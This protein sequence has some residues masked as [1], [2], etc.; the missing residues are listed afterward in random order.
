MQGSLR[1]VVAS[2]SDVQAERDLVQ[3]VADEVNYGAAGERN[4]VLQ[5]SRW[6]KDAFPSSTQAAHRVSSTPF[7]ILPSATYSSAFSGN[8]CGTPVTDA[9]SGTEHE[10]RQAFE[11]WRRK[12][13]LRS[14]FTRHKNYLTRNQKKKQTNGV[15]CFDSSGEFP[16]RGT[17]VAIPG[18]KRFQRTLAPASQ[19]SSANS[20]HFQQTGHLHRRVGSPVEKTAGRASGV[21]PRHS[22]TDGQAEYLLRQATAPGP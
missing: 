15:W 21:L 7:C 20:S 10:Y 13:L 16:Q 11:M 6:E 2:A 8:G 12:V 1:I 22:T 3:V 9:R 4:L 18:K 17:L 19:C 14:F 5:V